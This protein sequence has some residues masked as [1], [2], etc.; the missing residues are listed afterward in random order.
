[1]KGRDKERHSSKNTDAVCVLASGGADSSILIGTLAETHSPVVPVFIRN[2]LLWEEAEGYWLN[3]FLGALNHPSV[4]PVVFLELPM[5]DVYG[6]HWS[7]TGRAVPDQAS[8]WEEVYL[9]G[10]NLIL[11]SK[12]AVYCA[13][14]RIGTIAL[15]PLKTNRFQDSSPEFFSEFRASAERALDAPINVIAPFSQ[16]TKAEVLVRGRK[17][18]LELTF[19]CLNPHGR[20]HCGACNKCA[21]RML[22]FQEA[23]FADPT[24]YRNPRSVGMGRTGA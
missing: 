6:D 10:R 18:P 13:L 7:M 24:S 4:L 17:F 23:G 15:G 1:M 21:E 22:G 14:H 8:D 20:E 16:W 3:R 5:K 19:S 11:L 2:G 9:P 12:A